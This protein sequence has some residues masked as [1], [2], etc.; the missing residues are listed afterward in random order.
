MAGVIQNLTMLLSGAGYRTGDAS[1]GRVMPEISEPVI[2]LSLEH[3]DTEKRM[4]TVRVT[5]ISPLALG[6]RAC[7]DEALK[8]CK[9]LRNAGI[10]CELN[11]YSID[12]KTEMILL[13][14]MATVYGN[15]WSNSWQLGEGCGVRLDADTLERVVSFTAWREVKED[16]GGIQNARWNFRVEEEM[17]TIQEETEPTEPFVITVSHGDGQEVYSGCVLTLHKRVLTDGGLVQI[18]E[19]TAKSRTVTA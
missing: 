15:L 13:P 6:A 12:T 4:A 9:L 19:G 2:A 14:V 10:A 5:M 17:D 16:A 11:P 7:E 1:P 3:L 18:R 8:V